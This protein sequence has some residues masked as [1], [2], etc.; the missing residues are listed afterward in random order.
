[1]ARSIPDSSGIITSDKIR[2]GGCLRAATRASRGSVKNDAQNPF[3]CRI[4][5]N[6]SAIMRSSSTMNTLGRVFCTMAAFSLLRKNTVTPRD[7]RPIPL[8]R[9]YTLELCPYVRQPTDIAAD[10]ESMSQERELLISCPTTSSSQVAD[11][12]PSGRSSPYLAFRAARAGVCSKWGV[13]R[14]KFA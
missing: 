1:M 7:R 10:L 3:L 2:S 13:R 8:V 14:Y 12:R 4:M 6:V 5:V 11:S 9:A